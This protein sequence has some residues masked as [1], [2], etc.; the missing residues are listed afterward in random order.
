MQ[1]INS[2]CI[3]LIYLDPPIGKSYVDK[4]YIYI[5]ANSENRKLQ[6]WFK[7]VYHQTQKRRIQSAFDLLCSDKLV[8]KVLKE[9]YRETGKYTQDT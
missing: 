8:Y 2:E 7:V 1:G 9:N 3:D 6:T 5:V 4:K